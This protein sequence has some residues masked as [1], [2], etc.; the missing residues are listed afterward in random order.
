MVTLDTTKHEPVG[1]NAKLAES[2]FAG[3]LVAKLLNGV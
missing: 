3:T 1:E 2:L